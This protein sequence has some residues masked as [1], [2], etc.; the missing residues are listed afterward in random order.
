M[1]QRQPLTLTDAAKEAVAA[2]D[3]PRICR[4]ADTLRFKHGYG[5]EQTMT[6]SEN[7]GA[8]RADIEGF[9]MEG[10]SAFEEGV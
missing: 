1:Q 2:Q 3:G 10:D 9:F 8:D 5:Y 7:A 4:I 6:F